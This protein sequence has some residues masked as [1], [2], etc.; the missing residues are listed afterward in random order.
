MALSK[1]ELS[2]PWEQ[3][4]IILLGKWWGK[5]K[6]QMDFSEFSLYMGTLK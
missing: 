5:L 3:M 2:S 6:L 4:F 1:Q